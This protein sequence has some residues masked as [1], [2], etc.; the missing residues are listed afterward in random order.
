[1]IKEF[2]IALSLVVAPLAVSPAFAQNDMRH[3]GADM[4]RSGK[5]AGHHREAHR[6]DMMHS[7]NRVS[8]DREEAKTT[9]DLNRRE[10]GDRGGMNG[11]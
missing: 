5:T 7:K 2:A 6:H 3:N 10:L 4:H 8:R 11:R 1:M 9:S